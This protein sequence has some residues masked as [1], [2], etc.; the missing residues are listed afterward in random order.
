MKI[1]SFV[2]LTINIE[3]DIYNVLNFINIYKFTDNI[4]KI[5]Y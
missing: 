3:M 2:I 4:E 5:K 1:K